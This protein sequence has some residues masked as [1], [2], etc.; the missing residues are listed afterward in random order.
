MAVTLVAPPFYHL[1]C[2]LLFFCSVI[3]VKI[4][5]CVTRHLVIFVHTIPPESRMLGTQNT[6]FLNES[7]YFEGENF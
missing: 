2:H 1:L 6:Q 7:L 3:P 5:S 4:V